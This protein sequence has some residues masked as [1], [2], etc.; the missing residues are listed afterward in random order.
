MQQVTLLIAEETV[1]KPVGQQ[2][3][4]LSRFSKNWALRQANGPHAEDRNGKV[5]V[6]PPNDSIERCYLAAPQVEPNSRNHFKGQVKRQAE[7]AA[8]T[9]TR[10]ILIHAIARSSIKSHVYLCE[11][12][13]LQIETGPTMW[14]RISYLFQ[15]YRHL[16]AA[17]TFCIARLTHQSS[18]QS[19][20]CFRHL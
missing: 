17:A 1:R 13:G 19:Q 9:T 7:P 14:P 11:A 15:R 2:F 10:R 3:W 6:A 12:Q 16:K 5:K 20:P 8:K 18:C 4:S